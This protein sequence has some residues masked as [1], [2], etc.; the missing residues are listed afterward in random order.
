MAHTN[1]SIIIK[2][3][4]NKP[5]RLRGCPMKRDGNW[6]EGLDEKG[7]EAQGLPT[8]PRSLGF[9]ASLT[10]LYGQHALSPAAPGNSQVFSMSQQHTGASSIPP[11]YSTAFHQ[12]TAPLFDIAGTSMHHIHYQTLA[13]PSSTQYHCIHAYA[14]H[15]PSTPTT[16]G[17]NPHQLEYEQSNVAHCLEQHQPS[18]HQQQQQIWYSNAQEYHDIPIQS[19][20][21]LALPSFLPD[22]S[23]LL[24]TAPRSSQDPPVSL[25]STETSSI[26]SS[27]ATT[28]HQ[29]TAPLFDTADTPIHH[30]YHHRLAYYTYSQSN[31]TTLGCSQHQHEY[32]QSN[33]THYIEQHQS[34]QYQ[35]QQ[36]YYSI[37]QT[38][39]GDALASTDN[40]WRSYTAM[41]QDT[42]QSTSRLPSTSR[43]VV[44][45]DGGQR[46]NDEEQARRAEVG[47]LH[48]VLLHISR[49]VHSAYP[50]HF[51]GERQQYSS[52]CVAGVDYMSPDS[53]RRPAITLLLR[54]WEMWQAATGYLME[55]VVAGEGKRI[56]PPLTVNVSGLE[57]EERYLFFMDLMPT[58][59]YIY[60]FKSGCWICRQTIR[61]Y[62]PPNEASLIYVPCEV[63]ETGSRLMASGVDFRRVK[64]TNKANKP[65]NE[66]QIFVHSMQVYLPRYHLVRR[67]AEEEVVVHQQGGRELQN[68][69]RVHLEHVGTY[70]IPE[71]EFI[72]VTAYRNFH[73]TDLKIGTNPYATGFRNRRDTSLHP[74]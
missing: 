58:D 12:E 32:E 28:F 7:Q 65:A 23:S 39:R 48:S 34:S 3:E 17:C 49:G 21:S 37:A 33:V 27:Y 29:E 1:A 47:S 66:N 71:T 54:D 62:P 10:S 59:Q 55:M 38:D 11:S 56:Y 15:S 6:S 74:T 50:V 41:I 64:I 16:S 25:R 5:R 8:S 63:F 46:G 69:Q 26:S 24:P 60:T 45:N 51:N 40:T 72:T 30:P 20:E 4:L 36:T 68:V 43:M 9:E 53:T 22:C 2:S 67:L 31:P 35:Q 44:T 42:P 61:S 13:Y 57:A 19:Q 52:I 18:Q 73:I 70:V 14:A